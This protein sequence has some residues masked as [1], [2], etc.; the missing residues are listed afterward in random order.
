MKESIATRVG[1]IVSGSLNALIDA[2]ENIGP[3]TVMEE[4]IREIDGAV[5]S[6]RHELGQTTAQ[7][8]LANQ[9]I[10]DENKKHDDINDQVRLA[11]SQG[12][13]DLAEAGVQKLLDIEAQMPVLEQTLSQAREH[14]A[15]LESYLNALRGKKREMET[16][17]A[18]FREARQKEQASVGASGTGTP[19]PAARGSGVQASVERAESAFDRVI[20]RQSGLPMKDRADLETESKLADLEELKRQQSVSDRLEAIR[21]DVAGN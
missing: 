11:V 8:H 4:A 20:S 7:V 5:D 6:V 12:R 10:A 21:R 18:Q 3:E 1:R 17:M 13:D 19:G 9:R 14:A 16:E 2:A 15:E